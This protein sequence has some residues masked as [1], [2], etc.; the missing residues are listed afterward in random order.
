MHK[1]E[2]RGGAL[3]LLHFHARGAMRLVTNHEVERW[4]AGDLRISHPLQRLVSAENHGQGIRPRLLQTRQDAF[5]V[6]R[7][8][9]V[10]FQQGDVLVCAADARVG[11]NALKVHGQAVLLAPFTHRLRHKRDGGHKVE[12]ASAH[13]ELPL[14]NPECDHGLARA[15]GQDQLAAVVAFEARE[16]RVY[17]LTLKGMRRVRLRRV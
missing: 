10:Q 9:V 16:H 5:G 11:A 2:R 6:G 3:L 7:H 15:A 12:H 8:R 1:Q 14:R 13:A 4:R 17:R